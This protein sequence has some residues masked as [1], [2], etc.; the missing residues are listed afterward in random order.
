VTPIDARV[1]AWIASLPARDLRAAGVMTTASHWDAVIGVV[2]LLITAFL[3]FRLKP[4]N[5]YRDRVGDAR[6]RPWRTTAL[7]A[8]IVCGVLAFV[9]ATWAAIA[10]WREVRSAT[11]SADFAAGFWA[12]FLFAA[13]AL[14]IGVIAVSLLYALMRVLPQFWWVLAGAIC[15]VFFFARIWAPDTFPGMVELQEVA[16]AGAVRSAV[17]DFIRQDHLPAHEVYVANRRG[18]DADV[19]GDEQAVHVDVT[20]NMLG[21]PP[22]EARAAVGH[23]AGHHAHHDMLWFTLLLSA[24]AFGGFLVTDRLLSPLAR[25]FGARAPLRPSDP[26]GMPIMAMIAVAWLT[27]SAVAENNFIRIVNVGADRYSLDHAR[28]PDGLARWLLRDWSGDK[29]SP[30]VLEEVLFYN[31]PPLARR[32]RAIELWRVQ[33]AEPPP[34][35]AT[36]RAAPP[37]RA[38]ISAR[39]GG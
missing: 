24:L 33:H 30:G 11:G 14:V 28:A 27:L 9:R 36:P 31:H 16:P 32:L 13:P 26:G 35:L 38:T 1:T 10:L 2:L 21:E 19:V 39:S 18:Y 22:D 34:A 3:V 17:L 25:L 4:L 29:P 8:L 15:A 37:A 20:R 12:F 5:P 23:V 7:T 6:A